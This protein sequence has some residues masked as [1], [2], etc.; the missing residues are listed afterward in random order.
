MENSNQYSDDKYPFYEFS[1]IQKK[2]YQ[3][4]KGKEQQNSFH[5]D[6]SIFSLLYP[7]FPHPI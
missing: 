7:Y 5:K 4:D 6:S 1:K 3:K 2:G